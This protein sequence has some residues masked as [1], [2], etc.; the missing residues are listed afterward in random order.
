[1][2]DMSISTTDITERYFAASNRADLKAVEALFQPNAT[3]SSTHTGLYYGIAD[4]M[5]MMEGFFSSHTSLHWQVSQLSRLST[6][7]VE[8]SFILEGTDQSGES[9][10]R[11]G[12][13]RLVIEDGL[14]RHIEIR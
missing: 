2:T 3:Y 4:I 12:T 11:S 6:H 8:V 10:E 9:F 7:I 13:E 14:I 5:A 1:M